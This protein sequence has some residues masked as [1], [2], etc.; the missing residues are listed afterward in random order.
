MSAY[1]PDP[2]PKGR[3]A[4]DLLLFLFLAILVAI[5]LGGCYGTQIK[6]TEYERAQ[7]R[8]QDRRG[9]VQYCESRGGPKECWWIT[10]EEMRRILDRYSR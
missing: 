1:F 10:Q 5:L 8:A 4:R 9:M 7:K 2:D 3:T 6:P